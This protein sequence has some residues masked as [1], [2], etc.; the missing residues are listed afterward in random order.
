MFLSSTLDRKEDLNKYS[1]NV[2]LHPVDITYEILLKHNEGND[3][4]LNNLEDPIKRDKI[5]KVFY[6][7]MKEVA[8]ISNHN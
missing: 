5:K 6:S 3:F 2:N 8:S 1:E 7:L 4:Q